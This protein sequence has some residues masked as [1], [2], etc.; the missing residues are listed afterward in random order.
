ME[1]E[2]RSISGSAIVRT[3]PAVPLLVQAETLLRRGDEIVAVTTRATTLRV[4][5][6]SQPPELTAHLLLPWGA[7]S[8]LVRCPELDHTL[9]SWECTPSPEEGQ[10]D[11][12]PARP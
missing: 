11:E 8:A 12:P 7:A 6:E 9:A 10:A 5:P 1:G 3:L 4:R 2:T